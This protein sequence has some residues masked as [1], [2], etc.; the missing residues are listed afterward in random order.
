MLP[1][2]WIKAWWLEAGPACASRSQSS[3]L[4]GTCYRSAMVRTQPSLQCFY[5]QKGKTELFVGYLRSTPFP[6]T[7]R[8]GDTSV[9]L[10]WWTKL[11]EPTTALGKCT[12]CRRLCSGAEAQ[13]N[14]KLCYRTRKQHWWKHSRYHNVS[15]RAGM[16]CYTA[17]LEKIRLVDS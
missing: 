1:Q 12:K 13:S 11:N 5:T 3:L 10:R 9:Q 17:D 7:S 2:L 8:Q 16:I 4:Q 14:K 15:S 6:A